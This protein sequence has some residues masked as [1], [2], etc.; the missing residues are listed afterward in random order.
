MMS[1]RTFDPTRRGP[2]LAGV[3]TSIARAHTG[4]RLAALLVGTIV[5]GVWAGSCAE[6]FIRIGGALHMLLAT[7]CSEQLGYW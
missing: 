4:Y 5:I 1:T 6:L 3:S 2:N 7:P